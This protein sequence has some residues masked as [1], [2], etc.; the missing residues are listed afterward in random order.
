MAH[1]EGG[2][3]ANANEEL[4]SAERSYEAANAALTGQELGTIRDELNEVR[5]R[6]DRAESE[7]R[8]RTTENVPAAGRTS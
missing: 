6:I 1:C 8:R 4:G 3:Y 7:I 2:R 5:A